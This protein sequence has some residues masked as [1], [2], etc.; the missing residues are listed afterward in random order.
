M[1]FAG[2]PKCFLYSASLTVPA[3]ASV[4]LSYEQGNRAQISS[5]QVKSR[6]VTFKSTLKAGGCSPDEEG[7]GFQASQLNTPS[8]FKF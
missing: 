3:L 5:L 8:S 4:Q 7:F 6:Q 1:A 2:I